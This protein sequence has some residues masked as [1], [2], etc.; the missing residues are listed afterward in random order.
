M[1]LRENLDQLTLLELFGVEPH[2]IAEGFLGYKITDKSGMCLRFSIDP[3]T[4]WVQIALDNYLE[5][6]SMMVLSF[7]AV[8]ALDIIDIEKG[9]FAFDVAS[10]NQAIQIR[11]Q[12]ELRPYIEVT[13]SILKM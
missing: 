5:E 13:Q 2:I 9:V 7:E 1:K 3:I 4:Q 12:V 6:F 8:D 11:V 10:D